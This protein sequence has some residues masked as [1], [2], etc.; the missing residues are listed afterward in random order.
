MGLIAVQKFGGKLVKAYCDSRLIAGQVQGEVKAKDPRM[1]W[2]R[3]QV[4]HL[5][6]NFQSFILEQVP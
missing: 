6:G 1:L 3:N 2:Y 5:L 4:K